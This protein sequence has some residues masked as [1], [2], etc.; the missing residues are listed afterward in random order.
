MR[1]IAGVVLVAGILG[2]SGAPAPSQLGGG[3]EA[4]AG[5]AAPAADLPPLPYALVP[6][7]P[8]KD[9]GDT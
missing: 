6:L 8:E 1:Q 5:T 4:K 3:A 2:C 7:P 9:R